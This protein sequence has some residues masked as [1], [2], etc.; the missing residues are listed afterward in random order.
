MPRFKGMNY[1][2]CGAGKPIIL[3]HG[4]GADAS[5]WGG[6]KTD[7]SNDFQVYTIDF[8]GFG[9]SD[10]PKRNFGVIEYAEIMKSFIQEIVRKPVCVVGHSFGGRVAIVLANICSF[11]ERVVLVDSAGLKTRFS[12]S[13]FLAIKKYKRLKMRVAKGKAEEQ[14]LSRFGSADYKALD[15]VMRE[16]FVRVVNQDLSE[17]AKRIAVPTLLVWGRND[18]ETPLYM[19]KRLRK[20]IK[21]SELIVL[22]GGHYVFIDNESAF[23]K[24]L[25]KFLLG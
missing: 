11:V 2:V 18:K 13:K 17:Y 8:L 16:V 1:E 14:E 20:M 6:V 22:D 9:K 23:I 10:S 12:I 5:C 24:T 4:W 19:A 25:Y 15:G 7:L 21:R 3:M